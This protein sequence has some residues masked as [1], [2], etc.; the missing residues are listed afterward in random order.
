MSRE[1]VV[2]LEESLRRCDSEEWFNGPREAR[3]IKGEDKQARVVR[4][5]NTLGGDGEIEDLRTIRQ[6]AGWR[7]GL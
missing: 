6:E 1:G 2:G 5:N 3:A 4:R 7:G